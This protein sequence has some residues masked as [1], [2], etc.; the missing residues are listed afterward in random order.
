MSKQTPASA[1]SVPESGLPEGTAPKVPPVPITREE[2]LAEGTRRFGSNMMVWHFVCPACGH[3]QTPADFI[4]YK[5]KIGG[6]DIAYL[7]C[8]GRMVM[9]RQPVHRAF[10]QKQL[11]DPARPCDYTSGGLFNINPVPVVVDGTTTWAF[12]F[13]DAIPEED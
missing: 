4:P 9:E 2:W 6:P 10:G 8:F 11:G 5:D 7:A 13:A 12:A 1:P 3:V